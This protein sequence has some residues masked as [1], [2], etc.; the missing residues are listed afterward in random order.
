MEKILGLDLGTNS[1]GWAILEKDEKQLKLLNRG[2]RIFQEGVKIEKGVES[3]KAAERT[4]YR[5]ARRLK[6]RRKLRKIETLTVLSNYGYCPKINED[7]LK[8]WKYKKTYPNNTSLMDWLY[9]DN[10][11]ETEVRKK[12]IKNPYYY[13]NLAVTKKL[14]LNQEKDR[15]ILGRVFY[16]IAQRRGFLSNRLE[17]KKESEGAVKETIAKITEEK[18]DKTLGQFFY[19]K[20][21]NGEKIRDTYTHR[22]AHYLDEFKRICEI[23]K[24]PEELKEKLYK[25]IFFQRPLKSQRGHVGRCV[26]EPTKPRC[27]VS[28]PLFEEYRMLSFINNV[29]IKTPTDDNLRSLTNLE[30]QKISSLF[31]RKSKPYFDFEDIAKQL[32]PKNQYK[33]F[34]A[35]DKYPE[36][37]IFNYHMKTMVNGCPM[38]AQLQELFGEDFMNLTI[39][40]NRKR[41]NKEAKITLEDIWHVLYSFDSEERIIDFAKNRLN[42]SDEEITKFLKIHPKHEYAALSLKAIKKILP[43]LREGLIYPHAVFLANME[44]ILP[45]EIW[46]KPENRE[47]IQKEIFHII[48]TQN[49][50][51]QI[52]DAVNSIIKKARDEEYTWSNEAAEYFY[53]QLTEQ[54][55]NT[56]GVKKYEKFEPEKRNLLEQN[57]KGLLKKQFSKNMGRGEFARLQPILERIKEFLNDNFEIQAK[58]L[59]NIYHPSA[60]E[61]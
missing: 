22:I 7:D 3:S 36:D 39:K 37:Y 44:D 33:Y 61:V 11:N 18:G 35:K 14:D 29:K 10:Q 6:F 27:A 1:I 2:V 24:I 38:S 57:A 50:E 52:T 30:K 42:L 16:H 55:K 19:E 4:I 28:H 15:F 20:Y 56:V 45:K 17:G 60:I 5:S 47:L 58:D 54:L 34:K 25:A 13:R 8:N 43:Y 59:N 51:K 12:Q 21:L 31:F 32:A 26:F 23:Q 40:Y 53:K 41:D 46:G 48:W 49:E 9:T